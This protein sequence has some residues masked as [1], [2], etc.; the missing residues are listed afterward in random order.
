MVFQYVS[1]DYA[2]FRGLDF[3]FRLPIGNGLEF[4][5]QGIHMLADDIE[6]SLAAIGINEPLLG[7]PPFE[8]QTKLIYGRER[9]PFFSEVA[10]HNVWRQDRVATS[11]LESSSPGFSTFSLRGGLRL[12]LDFS[13]Q[14]G[15]ENLGD[16]FYFEHLNSFTQQRI[17]ELRRN[18]F[19]SSTKR[20][21]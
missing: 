13:L 4:R 7:I 19:L 18:F 12:P 9:L 5:T 16:K 2:N 10:M 17:P 8:I 14:I 1:G 3:T 6:E 21:L 11:R 20:F 15:V